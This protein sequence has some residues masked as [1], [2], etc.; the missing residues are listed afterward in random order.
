MIELL[1][2]IVAIEGFIATFFCLGLFVFF[3]RARHQI[4]RA[5]GYDKLAE[6]VLAGMT[7]IF[8]LVAQGVWDIRIPDFVVVIMRFA[9]FTVSLCCSIHLTHSVIAIMHKQDEMEYRK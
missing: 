9:M 5:V 3:V 8:T 4:G 1:Q 6:A 2:T 7:L